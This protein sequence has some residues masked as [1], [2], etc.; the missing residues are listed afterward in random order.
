M[1]STRLRR[2]TPTVRRFR[3]GPLDGRFAE[4][5]ALSVT[6]LVL[7]AAVLLG[8]AVVAAA[9]TTA[10]VGVPL[11]VVGWAATV[12]LAFATPLVVVGGV[13]GLLERRQ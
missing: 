12:G 10:P 13:V 1:K 9:A 11:L 5:L 4:T 7:M 3:P 6:A 8:G 2:T